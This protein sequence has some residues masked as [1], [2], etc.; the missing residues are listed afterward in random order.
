M[1]LFEAN[2]TDIFNLT[3]NWISQKYYEMN[4]TLFGGSLGSC[5]FEI[6]TT[7]KGSQGG[8]LGW[9]CCGRKSIYVSRA[10]RRMYYLDYWG[11]KEW[12][13]ND[14]FVDIYKPII[15][16]NGNY[17]WTEKAALSTL[18]H[19]MCHYYTYMYGIAPKQ[20]HGPE[21]RNIASIVSS[22]SKGFFTVER[23]ASAE[24][25]NEMTLN[26]DM[27]AKRDKRV[28]NKLNKITVM[29]IYKNNGEIRLVNANSVQV[30]ED[31]IKCAERNSST[32]KIVTCND[33]NLK[34][35]LFDMGYKA[36]MTKYGR[37]WSLEGAQKVLNIL[38]KYNWNTV[39]SK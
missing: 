23:V 1:D 10:T 19:E 22:K 36:C 3:V 21:F 39:Y 32:V 13:D 14:N 2:D 28:E 33:N 20:A 35:E 7:G 4:D 8:V 11:D 18:V 27:Q 37:Y 16:L 9:F 26:S 34:Q 25:M 30:I 29:L 31:G 15:K 12:V 6:F 38:D 17:T 24:Q 5:K